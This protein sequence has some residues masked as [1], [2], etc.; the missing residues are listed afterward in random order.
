MLDYSK[1]NKNKLKHQIK[2]TKIHLQIKNN[3]NVEK[4]DINIAQMVNE[5]SE[6]LIQ[7]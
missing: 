7:K 4:L 3:E 2:L 5:V 1:L 6:E